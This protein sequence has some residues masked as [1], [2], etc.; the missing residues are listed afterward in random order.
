M[1][2]NQGAGLPSGPA[3]H[4]R[5]K[6]QARAARLR[7]ARKWTG[8]LDCDTYGKTQILHLP[9]D[10]SLLEAYTTNR[11]CLLQIIAF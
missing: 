9:Q 4:H 7:V 6:Q 11:I 5:R 10:G 1:F 2:E 3:V 8:S